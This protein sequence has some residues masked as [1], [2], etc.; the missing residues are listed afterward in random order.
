MTDSINIF[1]P[2]WRFLDANGDPV[3]GG[4]LE[5]YLAGSSTPL[6]VYSGAGLSNALGTTVYCDSGGHPV[7]SSGSSTKV[8]IWTGT[9]DFKIVGKTSAGAT[10]GTLDNFPGALDTSTYAVTSARPIGNVV[11]K[12]ATTWTATTADGSGT[13]YNAN[14]SGGS[15]IATLPSAA[16]AANGYIL[17]IRHDGQGSSNTVTYQTVSSQTIKEGH[18]SASVTAGSLT[19]YGETVWLISDSAGWTV[20]AHVP[21]LTRKGELL[22]IADRL[23]AA[24]SSPTAGAVYLV[25]GTP[26]GTWLALG[27]AANDLVQASGLGTYTELVV[28]DGMLAYVAD[29]TMITQYR[30]SAWVDLSN[31]LAPSTS[32]LGTWHGTYQAT[33]TTVAATLTADAWTKHTINT[34]KLNTI[35]GAAVASNAVTLPA[36]K[37]LV[38]GTASIQGTA[39][40]TGYRLANGG[41]TTTYGS[42]Q[43]QAASGGTYNAPAIGVFDFSAGSDTIELQYWT[44]AANAAGIV[45]A[46]SGV[47]TYASLTILALAAVQG[48]QG[49]AGAQGA[50]GTDGALGLWNWETSTSAG[51]ASGAIRFN[52]ATFS[53]V[54]S[55]FMHE[56]DL[57]AT[58]LA[59]L[60][61]TWDDSTSTIKGTLICRENGAGGN[62]FAADVTALT[63][64]GSDVT[65]TVTH[66]ASGGS[67]GA[68]DDIGVV[69]IP[70]G[71]K[72]DTGAT[73]SAG[74]NGSAGAAGATGSTGPNTGLD[75]A[76]DTGTT[77]DPGSGKFGYDSATV[78]SITTVR[79]SETGRNGESLAALLATWDDSTNTTHFGHL[80]LFTL[81]DRTKFVEL[82]ITGTITDSGS[83]RT[84]PVTYTAGGTLH[85]SNDICAVMF[86]R[87][88]NKGA[89]GVGTGDVV[90]PAASVDS[91]IA[92]YDSTTGK[93]IKRASFTGIV[94]AASGVA[95][96]ATAGT[97]YVAPGGALGTPSS[98][99]G[100]YLTGIPIATG[101]SG[102][103]SGVATALAVNVGSAGAPV[104]L[105]GAGGT[106]STI[107]LTNGTGLPV[108]GITAS[109]STALGVGSVE[110]GHATDTTI[111]RLAA[112]V[113]T[114]EGDLIDVTGYATTATAAGTT[115]LTVSSK[116]YQFFTGTTTQTVVLPVT[117]TLAQGFRFTVVNNSTGNV[118][119]QSSGANNVLVMGPGSEADFVCI[120]TS[121]TS[122]ASWQ[123][124]T[125][126]QNTPINSQSAAYTTVLSDSGKTILHPS[127][128]TSARTWTID[129]NANVPYPVGTVITFM[130]QTGAGALTIAITTDTM[131]LVSAGTT[132]SR[133][134]ATGG[135]ATALKVAST[136]WV[137]SGSGLT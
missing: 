45:L 76:F 96:A 91:E 15:Q 114:I 16:T 40:A 43:G 66:R 80:R 65:I 74:A 29:E 95:S 130:N 28:S 68:G 30:G 83:Y 122:A 104:V 109:T 63:D 57:N 61:A 117:S 100:T 9:T 60:L 126:Y 6:T 37:Y 115:T 50:A 134:L 85:A 105:N 20:M 82:E 119:V 58:A 71:D 8:A 48:P 72:G 84:I 5:F 41:A 54:T 98:G 97:D 38:I 64:N 69:F 81:A 49:A 124:L 118:T 53:S 87:T 2:F 73:G 35:T 75:Y 129:S 120:L 47:E 106:P 116:R 13:L 52:N 33:S 67:F 79:I 4:S 88:G 36:G 31:I 90:G 103:G 77:G 131:Q 27:F 34:E 135:M 128:D 17:G 32:Y 11:A 56:T 113:A 24:P 133:T 92:L 12:A 51:P 93:L 127:A 44:T 3:S 86:E 123:A 99:T 101:I 55:V 108:A 22:V 110:L 21:A 70:K 111:A 42:A 18:S 39:G 23:T 46:D 107:T 14:V 132:G 136:T 19:A 112:G 1:P 59:A 7:A 78:A 137:I 102:L 25:N 94:K 125:R 10:L 26:T 89:D 62:F 121:G